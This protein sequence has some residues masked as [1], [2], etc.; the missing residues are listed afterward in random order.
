MHRSK[1]YDKD[2]FEV[3]N[4]RYS[5]LCDGSHGAAVLNNC[6]Y[7]ISMNGNALELTLLRAAASPQMRADNGLHSFTYAFTAWEGNFAGCDVV[8]QGYEL[9]VN[10]TITSGAGKRFSALAVDKENVILETMKP[11][12]DG[13]GDIILRL[14]ESKK[15]AVEA[16]VCLQFGADKV[17]LCDMLENVMEEAAV[18]DG[19]IILPFRAFEIK[20]LRI[21]R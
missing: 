12:E 5:A 7:G 18:A 2:R 16:E 14:Y 9:N 10:P 3:C 19:K 20:T 6:K 15:A 17:F 13:S 1:L 8:R 11:A 21:R 4:H